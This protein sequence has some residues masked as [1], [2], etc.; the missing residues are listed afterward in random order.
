MTHRAFAV[1]NLQRRILALAAALYRHIADMR[2]C[3]EVYAISLRDDT[4][5]HRRA[6]HRFGLR[7]NRFDFL[8]IKPPGHQ[9]RHHRY[10]AKYSK[11]TFHR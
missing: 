4:Q 7:Q 3:R 6:L 10:R 11:N 1:D 2:D 9:C 8:R 5:L